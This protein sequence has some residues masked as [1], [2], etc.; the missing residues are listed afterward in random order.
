[1]DRG[2]EAGRK[3][4]RTI[5]AEIR[6]ARRAAGLSLKAVGH[7]VG[8]S[9]AEISRIERT[10][11]TGVG[12]IDLYR[13]CAVVGLDLSARTYPGPRTLNDARH[14]KVLEK[15]HAYVHPSLGWATEVPFP[16]PGDQRA[17]DAMIRGRGWRFGVE[18]EM[19]P[20][21]GQSILRRLHLKRRDGLVDGV[22][23]L[24][25]HT[26]QSRMFRSEF[27]EQ[28]STEFSVAGAVAL[29]NLRAGL[30]PDGSS[31]VVI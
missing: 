10:Q 16:N 5:A 21:D 17:W 14:G 6:Q 4:F 28:L 3:A 11:I 12:L 23:L 8:L 26:R 15:L 20:I 19:N 22:I 30:P 24:L 18:C 29:R 1:V 9:A 31:I 7:E 2:N 27:R 13:L 25:P